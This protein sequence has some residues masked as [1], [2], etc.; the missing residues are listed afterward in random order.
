MQKQVLIALRVQGD[1]Q[2]P[3]DWEALFGASISG[4]AKIWSHML[5]PLV[6]LHRLCKEALDR[7]IEDA[8]KIGP[9]RV[10]ERTGEFTPQSHSFALELVG[11]ED[12]SRPSPW[13]TLVAVPDPEE[14]TYALKCIRDLSR[15]LGSM[16]PLLLR[17]EQQTSWPFSFGMLNT[18]ESVWFVQEMT[19]LNKRGDFKLVLSPLVPPP[20]SQGGV[21]GSWQG[22]GPGSGRSGSRTRR[23]G[24][25]GKEGKSKNNLSRHPR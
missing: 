16:Y 12:G 21:P 3:A 5:M 17:A 13:V 9:I 20:P 23:S 15:V 7:G 25:G 14:I 18:M 1:P 19:F 24:G 22:G 8:D 4:W 10:L 11:F 6:D 2:L